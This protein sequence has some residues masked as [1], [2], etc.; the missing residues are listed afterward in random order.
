MDG[1]G[2]LA[3]RGKT[4]TTGLA[5]ASTTSSRLQSGTE[6]AS[7]KKEQAMPNL[8]LEL[9]QG[10]A[11]SGLSRAQIGSRLRVPEGTRPYASWELLSEMRGLGPAIKGAKGLVERM[12]RPPGLFLTGASGVGK[13][14]LAWT[15]LLALREEF[16]GF[17]NRR[18]RDALE[19]LNPAMSW[20]EFSEA[21]PRWNVRFIT[22][23]DL[24]ARLLP[25]ADP[26][27]RDRVM[28]E[29]TKFQSQSDV[30]L[31]VL[32]DL[33]KVK[34]GDYVGSMLQSIVDARYRHGLTTVVLSNASPNDLGDLFGDALVRR[35]LDMTEFYKIQP[36]Q[37]VEAL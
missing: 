15:L 14:T 21:F 8:A 36:D 22:G 20:H 11:Q 19:D 31:L 18:V 27:S 12:G 3:H 16:L 34:P 17:W 7:E 35:L 24:Y 26:H 37:V 13:S 33:E 9:F 6:P 2:L 28:E 25:G 29:L 1:K 4:K 30:N 32:D 5:P 10:C 23:S